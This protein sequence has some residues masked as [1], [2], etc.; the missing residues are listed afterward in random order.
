MP[1]FAP[2]LDRRS[3]DHILFVRENTL[4]ARPFDTSRLDFSGEA[5]PLVEQVYDPGTYSISTTGILVYRK[6]GLNR[7]LTWYDRNGTITGT[8]WEPSLY[9][10]ANLSPDGSR[11]AVERGLAGLWIFD[12]ARRASTPL[13]PDRLFSTWS[14]D[15]KQ[16]VF[17]RNQKFYVADA[18]GVGNEKELADAPPG[19]RPLDWSAD[20]HIL[21]QAGGTA[22]TKTDTDLWTW[23]NPG[24]SPS[25]EKPKVYLGSEFNERWARFSPDGRFVAYVSDESGRGGD[26]YVRPFSDANSDKWPISTAGGSNPRWRQDGKEL[27]FMS[28][29]RK[30][31]SVDV[32]LQPTFKAG[33]PK[34]L[35]QT[36]VWATLTPASWDMTPDGERFLVITSPENDAASIAVE[37]NWQKALRK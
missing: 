4:M 25:G 24:K 11:V 34:V 30:L 13:G 35:F 28:T 18:N 9:T 31:M 1:L 5:V 16:L 14:P 2:V 22:R 6:G 3:A 29:D 27:L 36:A 8:A 26:I 23:L 17:V 10:Q 21:F 32:T 20:G 19:A 37:M 33:F 7:Q 15:G 12:L